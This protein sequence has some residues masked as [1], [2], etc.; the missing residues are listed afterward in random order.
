MRNQFSLRQSAG[1][2]T[3]VVLLLIRMIIQLITAY[4][5][6]LLRDPDFPLHL[7]PS[8]MAIVR[9]IMTICR[10]TSLPQQRH[11]RLQSTP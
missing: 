1:T 11:L 10:Y 7:N 9:D 5:E 2:M 6:R 4:R 3:D 8:T